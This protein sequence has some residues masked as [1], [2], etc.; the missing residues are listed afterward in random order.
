MVEPNNFY[1]INEQEFIASVNEMI[2]TR[3]LELE[4]ED[5]EEEI[6]V[7][8]DLKSFEQFFWKKT[9]ITFCDFRP[10]A[11][12]VPSP[13]GIVHVGSY[14]SMDDTIIP[15]YFSEESR[16][17]WSHLD[18]ER[19]FPLFFK[20]EY[21]VLLNDLDLAQQRVAQID[22]IPLCNL[23]RSIHEELSEFLDEI[24]PKA[25]EA[26]EAGYADA[27]AIWWG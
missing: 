3:E 22:V 1:M 11:P 18:G 5:I 6:P 8:E 9:S 16:A 13:R 2:A 26:I 15:D 23:D 17:I 25:K 12:I 21:Q 7:F 4:Y 19:G 10:M 24:V 14:A 27:M 20:D